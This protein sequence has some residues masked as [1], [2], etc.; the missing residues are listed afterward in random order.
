M[1]FSSTTS[2]KLFAIL[3]VSTF[4]IPAHTWLWSKF[5]QSPRNMQPLFVFCFKKKYPG[6]SFH[7]LILDIPQLKYIYAILAIHKS[8]FP[9]LEV[10]LSH[11][12]FFELLILFQHTLP[13]SL[14]ARSLSTSEFFLPQF[15]LLMSTLLLA[16]NTPDGVIV[17]N[18][19]LLAAMSVLSI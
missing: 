17:A 15:D 3:F 16:S 19:Q 8:I 7:L 12:Y 18:Y 13:F 6:F 14:L 5:E 10:S 2:Q 9:K 4:S 1:Q 11:I